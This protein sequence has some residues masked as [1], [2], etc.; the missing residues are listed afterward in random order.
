MS[1]DWMSKKHANYQLHDRKTWPYGLYTG[2]YWNLTE[3]L[4]W[5]VD[6]KIRYI[7]KDTELIWE[8]PDLKKGNIK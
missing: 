4:K 1:L 6:Q 8:N 7:S 5:A 2:S 3:A